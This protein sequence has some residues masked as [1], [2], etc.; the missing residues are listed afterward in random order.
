VN[1][2]CVSYRRETLARIVIVESDGLVRQI[3]AS[4]YQR[5]SRRF[6]KQMVQSAVRQHRPDVPISRSNGLQGTL[7]T[8]M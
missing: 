4:H 2:E 7:K 6:E 8:R 5:T 3:S 1:Q